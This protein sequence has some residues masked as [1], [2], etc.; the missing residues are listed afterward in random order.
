[1]KSITNKSGIL[2][3]HLNFTSNYK[4]LFFF[5]RYTTIQF[6]SSNL[7]RL[8][9]LKEDFLIDFAA[10]SIGLWKK[11]IKFESILFEIRKPIQLFF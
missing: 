11:S 9:L 10:K 2:D 4:K 5:F 7:K 1:M 3:V 6:D 8:K